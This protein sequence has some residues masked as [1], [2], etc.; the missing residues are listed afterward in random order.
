MSKEDLVCGY[1]IPFHML[2][3]KNIDFCQQRIIKT[4]N[5]RNV[6]N[7]IHTYQLQEKSIIFAGYG[8]PND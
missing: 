3:S 4:L 7:I 2:D 1:E 6:T 5:K 8:K